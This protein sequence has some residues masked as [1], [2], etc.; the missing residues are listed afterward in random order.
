MNKQGKHFY[1]LTKNDS[2]TDKKKEQL[3]QYMFFDFVHDFEVS[4]L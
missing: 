3:L 1:S 2:L 4:C